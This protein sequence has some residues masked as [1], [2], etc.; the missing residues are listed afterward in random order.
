MKTLKQL[1]IKA[2]PTAYQS[3][4]WTN[5]IML[6]VK[7]WLTQKRLALQKPEYNP[8]PYQ[9][10]Y[11]ILGREQMIDELLEELTNDS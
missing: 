5:E 9:G 4:Y 11:A 7:E 3:E 2:Q 8:S 1:I 6:A 10:A